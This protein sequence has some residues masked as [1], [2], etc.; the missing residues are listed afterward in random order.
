MVFKTASNSY[1][2][3][4]SLSQS[5]ET[6]RKRVGNLGQCVFNS[7]RVQQ[8]GTKS[9]GKFAVYFSV[10]R[11]L[12]YTEPFSEVFEDSFTAD[13]DFNESIVNRF[14]QT[15]QLYNTGEF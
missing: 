4:D 7:S 11:V 6:V 12:N 5:E 9:C 1:E 8:D 14:W 2:V 15:G 13:L 10:T 3:F